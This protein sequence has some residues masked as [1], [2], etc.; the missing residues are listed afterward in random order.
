MLGRRKEETEDYGDLIGICTWIA[1]PNSFTL[2]HTGLGYTLIYAQ[3]EIDYHGLY[4][5]FQSLPR[6]VYLTAACAQW[7]TSTLR[8]AVEPSCDSN[9]ESLNRF[10][11]I[12]SRLLTSRLTAEKGATP[13][14][15]SCTNSKDRRVSALSGNIG[16]GSM[17]KLGHAGRQSSTKTPYFRLKDK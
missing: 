10:S 3:D 8:W 15:I 4:V 11:L 12:V 7:N 2:R 13:K 9:I 6:D 17:L 5:S 1:L 14:I 16:R